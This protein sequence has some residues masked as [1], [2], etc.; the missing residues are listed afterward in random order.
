MTQQDVANLTGITRQ[1]YGMIENGERQ[2]YI[3]LILIEKLAKIFDISIDILIIYEEE[4][5]K[6]NLLLSKK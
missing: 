5:Y 3:S 4:Y 2:K 1:Y 6:R